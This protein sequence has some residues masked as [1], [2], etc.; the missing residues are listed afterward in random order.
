M[1]ENLEKRQ[2]G[3]QFVILDPAVPPRMPNKPDITMVIAACIGLGLII[4]VGAAFGLEY[5]D[6]TFRNGDIVAETLGIPVLATLPVVESGFARRRSW[7]KR[8]I[9][10]MITILVIAGYSYG[11]YYIK[12]RGIN[13]NLPL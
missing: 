11:I 9:F 1:A 10:A 13:I 2:K 7:I 12:S 3:E 8:G 5:L 6:N 4:G